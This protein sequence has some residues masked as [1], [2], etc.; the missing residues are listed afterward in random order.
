M[1]VNS[2]LDYEELLMAVGVV[3]VLKAEIGMGQV[4]ILE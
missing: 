4:E 3:F 2:I 1:S